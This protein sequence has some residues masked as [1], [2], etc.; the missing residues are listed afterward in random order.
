MIKKNNSD[1]QILYDMELKQ[2]KHLFGGWGGGGGGG[3]GGGAHDIMIESIEHWWFK[4]YPSKQ[5]CSRFYFQ[6]NNTDHLMK[7]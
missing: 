5:F 2:F 7:Q 3:G 6:V 4:Y 1:K